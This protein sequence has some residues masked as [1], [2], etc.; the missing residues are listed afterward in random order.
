MNSFAAMLLRRINTVICI[1]GRF[2]PLQIRKFTLTWV[3][4]TRLTQIPSRNSTC[5]VILN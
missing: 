1:I 3:S 4:S 5:Y 2:L